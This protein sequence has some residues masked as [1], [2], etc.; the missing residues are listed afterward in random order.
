MQHDARSSYLEAQIMTATPQK[1]RLM[2]IQG[3]IRNARRAHEAYAQQQF[4]TATA[5][6]ERCRGIIAELLSGVRQD[7]SELIQQVLSIYQ[8]LF[9]QLT[10][11]QLGRDP[12]ALT[13]VIEVLE[14]EQETWQQVCQQLGHAPLRPSSPPREVVASRAAIPLESRSTSFSVHG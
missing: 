11:V 1:L 14:V 2:L 5:A 8:F 4:E 12:A 3:A 9:Q 13:G 10:Q 6:T 7:R